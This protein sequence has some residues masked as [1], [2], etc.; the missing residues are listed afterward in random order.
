VRPQRADLTV[1]GAHAVLEALEGGRSVR[2]VYLKK[3]KRD[4]QTDKVVEACRSRSVS[5]HYTGADF[6]KQENRHHWVAAQ[7]SLAT[8]FDEETL[9]DKA[10]GGPVLL[11]HKINDP[12]NVGAILRTACG[13]RFQCVG[14][15]VHESAPLSEA[16]YETSAGAVSHLTLGSVPNAAAFIKKAKAA[17]Y[18]VY[19]ATMEGEPVQKVKFEPKTLLIVGSEG[20][21]LSDY[22]KKECDFLVGIPMKGKI[23][24]LNVSA[25]AAILLHEIAKH[26]HNFL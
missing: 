6:F 11:L 19:G 12:R 10:A 26:L 25:A 22:L 16:V 17:G 20:K 2:V 24:S 3:G 14:V 4:A 8:L 1:F 15:T 21:G 9:L 23:E 7:I 5:V 18:W 13:L